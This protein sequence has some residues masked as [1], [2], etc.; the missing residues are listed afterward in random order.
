M[1]N[2]SQVQRFYAV[3]DVLV[4]AFMEPRA[5]VNDE[6]A[7]RSLKIV[8]NDPNSFKENKN[9]IQLWYLYSFDVRTG[10]IIENVP[11]LIGNLVDFI[12]VK[13]DE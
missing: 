1:D 3:K 2:S 8:A 6:V 4:G 5:I 13:K 7:V 11:Y 10:L 12:E 9:D